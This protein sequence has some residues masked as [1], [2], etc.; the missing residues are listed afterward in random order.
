VGE[1]L[2]GKRPLAVRLLVVLGNPVAIAA[3]RRYL[4][5]DLNRLFGGRH[6]DFPP[7][8]ETERAR[9]LE[10][11][12]AAFWPGAS[13][14]PRRH[15]DLHTAIRASLHR[16]FAVLPAKV[17]PYDLGMLSW[18]RRAGIQALVQQISPGGT[19]SHFTSERFGAASCTL[20]LGKARPFGCNDPADLED[21]RRALEA[22][23]SADKTALAA[24]PEGPVTVY[25]V[26]QELGK[27]SE[28]F[29]LTF[30]D[31]VANF[32]PFPQGELL[33]EDGVH[34]FVV[35]HPQEFVLFPN[36]GVRPGLRAGLM[37]VPQPFSDLL[38]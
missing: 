28:A 26:S 24:L 38:Q 15:Y 13:C 33:A 18:L 23:L 32:T 30:A 17:G 2:T 16:K 31:S 6:R 3:G 37:L 19:F 22:G 7:G 11:V 34:R 25:R 27:H 29:R 12:L 1:L 21:V 14:L 20:E 36:A 9:Q 10:Q 35:R 4:Q 5:L 8:E